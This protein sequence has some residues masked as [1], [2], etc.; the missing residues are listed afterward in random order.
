[1]GSA[2]EGSEARAEVTDSAG[3]QVGD[4]N[5]QYNTWIGAYIAHQTVSSPGHFRGRAGGDGRNATGVGGIPDA[6]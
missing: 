2:A 1:M 5:V 4:G 6:C 3:V